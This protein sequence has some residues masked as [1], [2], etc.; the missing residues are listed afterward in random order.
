M[1]C[2]LHVRACS[3]SGRVFNPYTGGQKC[4]K[5]LMFWC[6][7]NF[8]WF[9]KIFLRLRS[10]QELKLFWKSGLLRK[11]SRAL[12]NIFC[13]LVKTFRA[14]LQKYVICIV[15]CFRPVVPLLPYSDDSKQENLDSILNATLYST[16]YRPYNMYPIAK[17]PVS[18][19]RRIIW[20]WITRTPALRPLVG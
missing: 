17:S 9:V 13:P 16:I 8:L 5:I 2:M 18:V 3:S 10:A 19:N 15:F 12:N 14:Y 4:K 11:S 20:R 1:D 6:F 7:R